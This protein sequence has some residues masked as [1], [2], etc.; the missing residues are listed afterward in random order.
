MVNSGIGTSLLS[1]CAAYE[2]AATADCSASSRTI[3]VEA[4]EFFGQ[5]PVSAPGGTGSAPT[6]GATADTGASRAAHAAVSTPT[7]PDAAIAVDTRTTSTERRPITD[8]SRQEKHAHPPDVNRPDNQ[9]CHPTFLLPY[10][11]SV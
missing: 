4:Y 6:A 3:D 9:A 7:N 2:A 11:D 1:R 8:P 5:L 10:H